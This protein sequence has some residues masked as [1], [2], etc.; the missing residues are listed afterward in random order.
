MKDNFFNFWVSFLRSLKSTSVIVII[1]YAILCANFLSS[2]YYISGNRRASGLLIDEKRVML[3]SI[4]SSRT[5]VFK[6]LGRPSFVSIEQKDEPQTFYYV[7]QKKE[8]LLPLNFLKEKVVERMILKIS[9]GKDDRVSE[10]KKIS[11]EEARE[12]HPSINL[13]QVPI[14]KKVGF[15]QKL[16][17]S[18]KDME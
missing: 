17:D 7:S 1:L 4:G 8:R 18:R 13:T 9:F 15:F 3:I 11:I 5:H 10:I 14:S 2:C 6:T 12:L 16:S